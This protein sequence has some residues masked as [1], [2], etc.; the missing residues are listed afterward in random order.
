MPRQII[1]P[2]VETIDAPGG[3]R[4]R[5]SHP[6]YGVVRVSRQT[7]HRT[8]FGSALKH[9][10]YVALEISAAVL[11]RHLSN[12]WIHPRGTL[13]EV[14]LSEA[15]W[16]SMISSVGNGSGTQCT[17]SEAPP[18]GTPARLVPDMPSDPVK[19]TFAGEMRKMVQSHIDDA[20]AIAKTLI[21]CVA[22]GR[23]GKG[24]LKDMSHRMQVLIDKMSSNAAF[25]QEQFAETMEQ[26]VEQA[27]SEIDGYLNERAR[28]IGL[29]ALLSQGER[30]SAGRLLDHHSDKRDPE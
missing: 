6:A 29:A 18:P 24:D 5:Y 2:E 25:I 8:L 7:G 20:R 21:E 10:H 11:D 4:T 17:I 12:N 15:Q 22:V 26:S 1:E 9:Q 19:K 16:A 28:E 30:P 13:I 3:Q 27:K 23:A 14:H